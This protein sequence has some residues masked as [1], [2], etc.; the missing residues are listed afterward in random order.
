MKEQLIA[1]VGESVTAQGIIDGIVNTVFEPIAYLL[2]SLGFLVFMWGLIEFI[3][4]PTNSSIKEK[5]K[6][7]M[8]FGILGLLIM[9][10]V[11]GIV[12]LVTSTL[13]IDCGDIGSGKPCA[14]SGG[15]GTAAP[16]SPDRRSGPF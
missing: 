12:D 3:A 9:V 4:N 14:P 7:H 10:S 8:I 13:G 1:A 5:G 6:Q 16:I 2:F 15:G 11:W